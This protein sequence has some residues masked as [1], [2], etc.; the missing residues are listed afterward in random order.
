MNPG[1][2]P[3]HLMTNDTALKN[4]PCTLAENSGSFCYRLQAVNSFSPS[5]LAD[6]VPNMNENL[7]LSLE[8]EKKTLKYLK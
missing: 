3:C 8:T 5:F 7:V 2:E 4:Y 6:H 1:S